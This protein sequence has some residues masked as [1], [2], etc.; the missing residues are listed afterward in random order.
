MDEI[1]SVRL[2]GRAD[3]EAISALTRQ[4]YA[5]WVAVIGREPVPMTVDYAQAVAHHRFDL[6]H[7][8]DRLAA[9]IETVPQDGELLIVN[10]AVRPEFQGRGFGVRLLH[11]AEDLAVA[12]DLA[13]T[14]L[15]TNQLFVGN[16]RLYAALGYE[17]EREEAFNG[18][19]AVHMCKARA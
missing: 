5:K 1:I 9:L 18:G 6:L 3:A 11:L 14:R 15:Y 19:V 16:L 7:A 2:G 8:G 17:V 12:A 10:V 13:G 4:A